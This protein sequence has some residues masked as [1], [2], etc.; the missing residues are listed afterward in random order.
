MVEV[1]QTSKHQIAQ[2]PTNKCRC[3]IGVYSYS[4]YSMPETD[5]FYFISQ[6]RSK[7][8]NRNKLS[9][10]YISILINY[11]INLRNCGFLIVM[12]R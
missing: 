6:I 11:F 8:Q 4:A 5:I 12:K 10:I 9:R 3:L 7:T 1:Q 2:F